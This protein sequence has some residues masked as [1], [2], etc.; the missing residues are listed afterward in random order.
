MRLCGDL[1]LFA[2][3]SKVKSMTKLET[4]FEAT[5]DGFVLV[6]VRLIHESPDNGRIVYDEAS[7]KDLMQSLREGGL[8]SGIVLRPDAE[9][10][11]VVDGHRRS[12]AVQRLEWEVVKCRIDDA[13]TTEE[14]RLYRIAT[15]FQNAGATPFEEARYLA[16]ALKNEGMNRQKLSQTCGIK[17]GTLRNRLELLE[18]P[19]DVAKRVGVDGFAVEHARIL[20]SLSGFPEALAVGLKVADDKEKDGTMRS[21][22]RFFEDVKKA[23]LKANLA[24]DPASNKL[25]DV[26]NAFPTF[27]GQAGKLAKV[28]H[29]TQYGESVLVLDVPAFDGLVEKAKATLEKRKEKEAKGSAK[30]DADEARRQKRRERQFEIER[31][32]SQ[33]QATAV[34]EATFERLAGLKKVVAADLA[35]LVLDGLGVGVAEEDVEPLAKAAGVP[36]EHL[37]AFLGWNLD[38]DATEQVLVRDSDAHDL[39]RLVLAVSLGH[40]LSGD[41]GTWKLLCRHWTGKTPEEWAKEALERGREPSRTKARTAP[42]N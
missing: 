23:L 7:M 18:F 28:E 1:P 8:R 39:L 37:R 42:R 11:E 21:A 19:E 20:A 9:G 36:V 15:I 31:A 6:P 41:S 29:K 10:Y 26:R 30:E 22:P 34:R 4:Q 3:D 16:A 25:W 38:G 24:R 27:E 17:P 2:S 5:Q 40:S 32:A 14:A 13:M 12:R 33:W 35:T